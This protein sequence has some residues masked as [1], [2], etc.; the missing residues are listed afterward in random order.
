MI[1]KA[2]ILYMQGHCLSAGLYED[3]I[4][5]ARLSAPLA[6]DCTE[7]IARMAAGAELALCPGGCVGP[8]S[9]GVYPIYEAALT[10]AADSRYGS[11]SYD[12]VMQRC[13]AAAALLRIPAYFTDTVSTEERLPLCRVRS[14]ADVPG[15]SRGFRAEHLAA[16]T[17]A[18]GK[19]AE[20]GRY[21]AVFLDDF[22]SVG[23]YDRG[24]CLDMN[25]CI[26][27]EG[28]MGFASSG[29]VPCA[30]LADYFLKNHMDFKTMEEQLLYKSGLL[31]YLGTSDPETVDQLCRQDRQ[32]AE[33]V[34]AM[35]YQ[36]A[37]WLGSSALVLQGKADGII[38]TGKGTD[39]PYLIS[40][41]QKKVHRI[42]PVFFV[43]DPD[44]G[45]YLYAKAQLL[46]SFALPVRPYERR[47]LL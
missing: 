23:A 43:P 31:Q 20:E 8:L 33:T 15:Y 46:N 27:A 25:D 14:H 7:Q 10:D 1:H 11:C 38:I 37:K 35:S 9:S 4:C 44:L 12:V 41:L 39:C 34:D 3:H 5:T 26:G 42:A 16:I 18:S 13:A 21:I 19:R 17:K 29:D 22:V 32:A 47:E 36:T 28:P 45:D 24:T 2:L 6:D 30:Q 40:G